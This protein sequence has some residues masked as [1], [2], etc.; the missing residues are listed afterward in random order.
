MIKIRSMRKKD[1]AKLAEIYTE[2]YRVF[3]TGEQWT[4]KQAYKFLSYLFKKQPDLT[5]VAEYDDEIVGACMGV[6]KPWWDGN[7]LVDGEVFVHPKYQKRGIATKLIKKRFQIAL[8]KYNAKICDIITFKD[9]KHPYS[10]HKSLG[11]KEFKKL[12]M[13]SVDIKK[14]LKNLNHEKI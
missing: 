4:K 1:I 7:H 10:W 11:Y 2:V 9:F 6:I 13:M 8:K 5:F 14:I 3:D 12:V